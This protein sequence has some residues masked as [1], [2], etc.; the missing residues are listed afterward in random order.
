MEAP[1]RRK[2]ITPVTQEPDF[3]DQEGEPEITL[4]E[5]YEETDFDD[6]RPRDDSPPT[7]DAESTPEPRR[8]C[9]KK[10]RKLKSPRPKNLQKLKLAP[11]EEKKES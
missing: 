3:I 9:T 7:N 4:P 2:D 6:R 1:T 5:G 8:N 10:S 11:A